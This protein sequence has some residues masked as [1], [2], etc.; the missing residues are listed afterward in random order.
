M[1]AEKKLEQICYTKKLKISRGLVTTIYM[2]SPNPTNGIHGK[3]LNYL[4]F[5]RT[6]LSIASIYF[7]FEFY[8][9]INAHSFCECIQS[10]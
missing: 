1:V 4:V 8:Y 5:I 2:Q 3:E 7:A 10:T 9:N 6:N